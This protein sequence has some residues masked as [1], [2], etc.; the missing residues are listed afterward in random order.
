L[1][2]NLWGWILLILFAAI[3]LWFYI[4][5]FNHEDHFFERPQRWSLLTSFTVVVGA[6]L[7]I[8]AARIMI[9]YLT[10]KQRL[11]ENYLEK[12]YLQHEAT[13]L[14]WL[15][16]LSQGLITPVMQTY[17]T[18]GFFFNYWF[19]DSDLVNAVMGIIVS[20]ILFMLL[21]WQLSVPLLIINAL[22]GMLLAWTYLYTQNLAIT[23]FLAII[24]GLLQ[25]VLF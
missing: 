4:R 1:Q 2:G 8:T 25:V 20:G 6:I 19:R 23:I 3:G 17:L 9:A 12:F 16:I 10:M 13:R 21:H 18:V 15:L 24:N 22:L 7:L 5:Q 14:F 11:P